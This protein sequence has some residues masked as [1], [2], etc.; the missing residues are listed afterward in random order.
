M[1]RIP[2]TDE[3]FA[4][5]TTEEIGA[6]RLTVRKLEAAVTTRT[7]T[8]G[9]TWKDYTQDER[10]TLIEAKRAYI[11][12][13]MRAQEIDAASKRARDE[14]RLKS[15]EALIIAMQEATK[16]RNRLADAKFKEAKAIKK[17]G[18]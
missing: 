14:R 2:S 1:G 4:M 3:I 11:D 9:R 15:R 6:A 13:N 7:S 18:G 17:V 8:E 5:V 16:S 12:L 10:T